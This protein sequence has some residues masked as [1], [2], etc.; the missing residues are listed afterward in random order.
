MREAHAKGLRVS[1]HV[2]HGMIAED[3]VNAGFDELQHIN[4][5]VLDLVA[6]RATETQTPL[7]LTIAAEHAADIDLDAPK[8]RALLDLLVKKKTVIDPTLNVFED[9]MTI[10]PDHPSQ[11][12]API[13]SRLPVQVQRGAKSGGLP[14]PEGKEAAF[15]GRGGAASQLTKRLWDRHVPLVA[16]TDNF[17]GVALHRELESYSEIG[18]PQR[19]RP[20][21]R[22]PSGLPG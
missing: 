3:A 20:R 18:D 5:L 16:G 13:L 10:R 22:A 7:R 19:R 17:P 21:H 14:V 8:T 15:Q 1:G 12:I 4:F 9:D 6:D 11:V 2:P